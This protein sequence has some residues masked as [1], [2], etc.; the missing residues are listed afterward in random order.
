[1]TMRVC[2]SVNDSPRRET[3]PARIALH[4]VPLGKLAQ[5]VQL[6]PRPVAEVAF[7]KAPVDAHARRS[8][9]GDRRGRLAGAFERRGVDRVDTFEPAIRSAAAAA[10][11]RPLSARWRPLARPGRLCPVVGVCPCRTNSTSVAWGGEDFL[12]AC[13][14]G[15]AC[16]EAAAAEAPPVRPAAGEAAEGEAGGRTGMIVGST[17][18][19]Q[20]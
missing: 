12:P 1:M 3:K 16:V 14:R 6:A 18:A 7:E 13:A 9:P 17:V 19:C 2:I 11:A 8:G 15:A 5:I 20:A 10:C 4:R